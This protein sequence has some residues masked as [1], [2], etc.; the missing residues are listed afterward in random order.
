MYLAHV[1]FGL[2]LTSVG[3]LFERD[4]TT[5]AHAC[6]VVEDYRDDANFDRTMELL[7]WVARSLLSRRG[8][9]G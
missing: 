4:R 5:V 8:Q 2:T 9:L 1:G 7:E 6:S 3:R